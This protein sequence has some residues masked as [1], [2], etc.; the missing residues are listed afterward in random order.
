[1]VGT[2][3]ELQQCLN[4]N[5]PLWYYCNTVATLL[6]HH[7]VKCFLQHYINILTL[8]RMVLNTYC[9]YVA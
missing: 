2:V 1:M 6:Q 4:S 7:L 3:A 5:T 9:C 8:L